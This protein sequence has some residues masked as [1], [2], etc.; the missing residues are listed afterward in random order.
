MRGIT[1][2]IYYYMHI[3]HYDIISNFQMS[4]NCI[5]AGNVQTT[6]LTQLG[7][8]NATVGVE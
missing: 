3:I 4:S 6:T 2:Q 8:G 7:V 1:F 5:P